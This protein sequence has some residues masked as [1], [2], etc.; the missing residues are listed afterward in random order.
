LKD[1]VHKRVV[2]SALILFSAFT[3]IE[4]KNRFA[5]K[6]SLGQQC[7]FAHEGD[8]KILVRKSTVLSCSLGQSCM[9]IGSRCPML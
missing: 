6:N 8:E 2:V 1:R 3:G 4:T 9:Y 5:V 7:Y